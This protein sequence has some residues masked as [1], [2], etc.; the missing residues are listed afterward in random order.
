MNPDDRIGHL[1]HASAQRHG[2]LQGIPHFVR[3]LREQSAALE[4]QVRGQRELLDITESILATLDGRAV[5]E[6]ITDR[7]GGLVDCDN[8]AIEIVDP[9]TGL[10]TPLT[11]RGVHADSYLQP[12]EV[13]E[14][15]INAALCG[16]WNCP[17]LLVTGDEATC[18][19]SRELL[20]DG[21]TTV[22][23]KKGLTRFSAR[24][25]PPSRAREMIEEGA[26]QALRNLKAVAP[27]KPGAPSEIVVEVVSSDK[28]DKFLLGQQA[29]LQEERLTYV[30]QAESL[31]AEADQLAAEREP[32]D[33]QFDEESGEGDT[34]A[35]ER[36]RDLA[37]S[38]QARGAV[39]EIDAAL[40][41]ILDGSYGICEQCGATIPR[42]R[43]RAIP[44]AALC[45]QCKSMGLGRR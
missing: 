33:V 36:E 16:H 9:S 26:R 45:V 13:G 42:E 30:H 35:V 27:Y 8:I 22:A 5:L 10:L 23:V 38:F 29:A 37:L 44:Y 21:L 2:P 34:L 14:T 20:G 4:R 17:V 40:A 6:S 31:Q 41:K 25:I 32:G 43:L 1:R 11:A 12:W 15:G 7:L 39:D 28:L 19:E 3:V 24:Q 18:K